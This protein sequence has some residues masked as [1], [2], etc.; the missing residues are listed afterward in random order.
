MQVEIS[1]AG[2]D[3]RSRSRSQEQVEI[4]GREEFARGKGVCCLGWLRPL[5]YITTRE[6]I[7]ERFAMGHKEKEKKRPMH[8]QQGAP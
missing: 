4:A 8:E 3:L 2:R 6:F 5:I 1:G 7:M